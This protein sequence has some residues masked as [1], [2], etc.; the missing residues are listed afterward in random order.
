MIYFRD[1]FQGT[2]LHFQLSLFVEE[3]VFRQINFPDS[4]QYFK[5]NIDIFS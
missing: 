3:L 4:W 5:V 1:N 2:F